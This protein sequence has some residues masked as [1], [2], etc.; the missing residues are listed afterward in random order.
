MELLKTTNLEEP[1]AVAYENSHATAHSSVDNE[2]KL[3]MYFS[4]LK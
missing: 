1:V 4:P 2:L 3:W